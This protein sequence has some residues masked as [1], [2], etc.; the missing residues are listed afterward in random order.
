MQSAVLRMM[1]NRTIANLKR[2][3]ALHQALLCKFVPH[4]RGIS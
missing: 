4:D 1:Q 3:P 2:S